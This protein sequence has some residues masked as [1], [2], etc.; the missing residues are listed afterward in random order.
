MLDLRD[1]SAQLIHDQLMKP[2]KQSHFDKVKRRLFFTIRRFLIKTGDPH[3][4]FHFADSRIVVPLSHMLPYIVQDFP[5]YSTNLTR[6]SNSVYEKYPEMIAI[7]VGANV[8]DSVALMRKSAYFPILCI[9][10]DEKFFNFLSENGL[11]FQNVQMLQVY[12]SDQS[13]ELSA[14]LIS[15]DGTA[16]VNLLKSDN[17]RIIVKTLSVVCESLIDFSQA[18]LLK[19]DTDGFDT[20][21]IRGGQQLIL[22]G[23]PV[24]FFEYDPFFL[25][26]RDSK[27]LEVFHF[28]RN[29]GYSGLLLYDNFGDFLCSAK[30]SDEL[31]LSEIT[32]YYTGRLSYS[33]LDICA[34]HEKDTDLFEK[35]RCSEQEYSVSFRSL[36]SI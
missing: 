16:T 15:K 12:L 18:K 27:Y 33:Y 20:R 8:G 19:I 1:K 36:R 30:C 17:D 32:S 26:K 23:N 35:L 6:I 25:L 14:E 34:F 22:E 2:K 3:V 29:L 31:F 7:D 28:L 11:Q 5:Q 9:E 4:N 10:G 13:E 24:I 21:I